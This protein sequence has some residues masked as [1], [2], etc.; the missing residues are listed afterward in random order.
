[1]AD[2]RTDFIDPCNQHCP[3]ISGRGSFV[4]ACLRRVFSCNQHLISWDGVNTQRQPSIGRHGLVLTPSKPLHPIFLRLVF[5][6]G[7][8]TQLKLY[9]RRKQLSPHHIDTV[10]TAAEIPQFFDQLNSM[11]LQRWGKPC[12]SEHSLLFHYK[13]AE[14]FLCHD[15]LHAISLN[16]NTKIQATCYDITIANTRFSLQLGFHPYPNRKVSMGTLMLG[17]A[18][19]QA[20]TQASVKTYDLL[21][22]SGK[23]FFYKH[24]FKGRVQPFISFMI[25]MGYQSK[26]IY[27]I[28]IKLRQLKH[29]F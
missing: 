10:K 12:F 18:I 15:Q 6:L 2:Q 16:E 4:R 27:L 20:H 11:R 21:A 3:K 7:K 14:Y 29:I 25:P 19:E 28:K 8:N 5:T 24:K 23:N 26:T 17:Y 1:M 13:I 9:N 22:G